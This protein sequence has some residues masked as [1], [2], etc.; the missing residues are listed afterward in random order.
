MRIF[1]WSANENVWS[2]NREGKRKVYIDVWYVRKKKV[3]KGF[4]PNK[5]GTFL[6]FWTWLH[7]RDTRTVH[8]ST[9]RLFMT[10]WGLF[11]LR[12]SQSK[13]VSNFVCIFAFEVTCLDFVVVVAAALVVAVASTVLQ[14]CCCLC[15]CFALRMV[16]R[17]LRACFQVEKKWSRKSSFKQNHVMRILH[18]RERERSEVTQ[19]LKAKLAIQ[20]ENSFKTPSH[21]AMSQ[22][23]SHFIPGKK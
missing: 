1:S 12:I 13:V 18:Q 17:S 23:W 8:K 21:Q 7:L 9:L 22:K 16:M 14:S 5:N 15:Y 10:I 3:R 11:S 2:L 19:K 6:Y 20:H 4:F